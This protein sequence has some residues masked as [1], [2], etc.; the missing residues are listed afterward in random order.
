MLS[1][2]TLPELLIIIIERKKSRKFVSDFEIFI[3]IFRKKHDLFSLRIAL[4][5]LCAP[6]VLHIMLEYERKRVLNRSKSCQLLRP[7]EVP[8][9]SLIDTV[10]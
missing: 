10:F 7:I 8:S 3:F 5:C 6:K 1:M 2:L 4:S 9:P